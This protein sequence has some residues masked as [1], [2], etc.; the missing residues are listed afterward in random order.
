MRNQ[1]YYLIA[2]LLVLAT[3]PMYRYIF[4]RAR[5]MQRSQTAITS[6]PALV[7]GRKTRATPAQLRPPVASEIC[8]DGLVYAAYE[9]S[10]QQARGYDGVAVPC[11]GDHR[12]SATDASGRQGFANEKTWY[13]YG[14]KLPDG[15]KCSAADGLVYRTRVE[16]GATAIEPLIR[17]G[18]IVRCGGDERSSHRTGN[19]ERG[20]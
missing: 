4:A 15:Y 16:N 2:A 6:E 10:Y 20:G 13:A 8:K 17:D 7:D 3:V 1:T 19:Q 18:M 12:T 9:G 11:Q 14:E 5:E